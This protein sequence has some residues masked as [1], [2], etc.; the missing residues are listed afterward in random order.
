MKNVQKKREKE[1]RRADVLDFVSAFFHLVLTRL[2]GL[3]GIVIRSQANVHLQ[4][5]LFS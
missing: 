5:I 1:P 2:S 4:S 3:S